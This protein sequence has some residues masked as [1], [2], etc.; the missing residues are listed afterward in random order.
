MKTAMKNKFLSSPRYQL[1]ARGLLL[2]CAWLLLGS[3]SAQNLLKNP[4]FESPLDPWDPLGL[5]GGKT[6]WTLVYALG[7]P[8]DWAIKDRTRVAGL[9]SSIGASLRPATEQAT[10]AYYTQTVSN[11]T[12]NAN[13]VVSGS[14]NLTFIGNGKDHVY[15]E[16]LGG[17]A[18]TTSVVSPDV[19][20]TGWIQYSVTNA[21]TP[22]GTLEVRIHSNKETTPPK[23]PGLALYLLFDAFFDNFSLTPQ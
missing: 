22:A 12:A 4:G 16:T 20:A 2:G 23:L 13:Y 8:G 5:S 17:P 3:A 9:S 11:L 10:H 15:I 21:A 19:S 7:G 6:N 18:G 14:I 1:A